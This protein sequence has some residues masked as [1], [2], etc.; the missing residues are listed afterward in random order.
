MKA[1]EFQTKNQNRKG[2]LLPQ[3]KNFIL[4]L[5]LL[6]FIPNTIWSQRVAIST[7]NKDWL[8]GESPNSIEI[9]VDGIPQSCLFVTCSKGEIRKESADD[10][11]CMQVRYE[12]LYTTVFVHKIIGSD[13]ILIGKKDFKIER[14]GK[15]SDAQVNFKSEMVKNELLA[16]QGM[17]AILNGLAINTHFQIDSFTTLIVRN[18]IPIDFIKTKGRKFDAPLLDKFRSLQENDFVYFLDIYIND[19]GEKPL[20]APPFKIK[21]I[22]NGKRNVGQ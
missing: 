8:L 18:D 10:F 7:E 9:T 12:D 11:Y 21:I 3:F 4:L 6:L 16:Q 5:V 1:T 19:Y 22:K 20:E 15:F 17:R 2:V 14:M 13:T